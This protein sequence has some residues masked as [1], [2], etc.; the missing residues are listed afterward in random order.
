MLR[1]EPAIDPRQET[2]IQLFGDVIP[3]HNILRNYLAN[4]QN[5]LKMQSLLQDHRMEYIEVGIREALRAE[6]IDLT[7]TRDGML[8][9]ADKLDEKDTKLAEERNRLTKEKVDLDERLADIKTQGDEHERRCLPTHP[10]E[11]H[12]WCVDNATRLNKIIDVYNKD[13]RT[14]NE[15]VAEWKKQVGELQPKWDAFVQEIREWEKKIQNLI[16]RVE[17]HFR[18][19]KDCNYLG[20]ETELVPTDPIT[21]RLECKYD[22]CGL[23]KSEIHFLKVKPTPGQADFLCTNPTPMCV[24]SPS[25]INS[26]S[27]FKGKRGRLGSCN[28]GQVK[29]EG[30]V[31]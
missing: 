5:H 27:W 9:D 28:A 13:V 25:V 19:M 8:P 10:P 7:D 21:W 24:P 31:R 17:S 1:A 11:R 6:G 2:L 14:H 4:H 23:P 26:D 29:P 3:L 18:N 20:H 16:D 12:Q 15:A 30:S 22:C